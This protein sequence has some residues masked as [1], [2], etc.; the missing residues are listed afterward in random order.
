MNAGKASIWNALHVKV[1]LQVVWKSL[2]CK[3][4]GPVYANVAT[5]A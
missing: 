4:I 2:Q 1:Q 5:A 3:T